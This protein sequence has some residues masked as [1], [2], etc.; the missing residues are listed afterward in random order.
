MSK[1][2]GGVI[3]TLMI[4]VSKKSAKKKTSGLDFPFLFLRKIL[5]RGNTPTVEKGIIF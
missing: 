5:E 2:H 1:T 3:Q 4:C